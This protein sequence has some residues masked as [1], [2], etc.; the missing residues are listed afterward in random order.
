MQKVVNKCPACG[1]LRSALSAQCPE[2]GYDFHNTTCQV[3]TE[4]NN[5]LYEVSKGMMPSKKKQLEIIRSFTIPQI[6]EELLDLLI[7]I[8]PKATQKNSAVTAEWRLR[9]KE[10]IKRAKMAFAN[11]RKVLEQ[12]QQ[13]EDELTKL[14]RQFIKQW[15]QKTSTLAKAVII[16]FLVL[17]ILIL[18][19]AKDISP[20]AYAVRFTNA[21]EQGKHDKALDYLKKS[22]NMGMVI[23]EPYL[24]LVEALIQSD[25]IIEAE[26]LFQ[27]MSNYVHRG[28]N[29]D[30]LSKTYEVF[31]NYYLAKGNIAKAGTF[32][33]DSNGVVVILKS[34]IESGDT[35]A[36]TKFYN[37][38][39]NKLV[40]YDPSVRQRV[41]KCDDEVVENF[42]LENNLLR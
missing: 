41:L 39:S 40:K 27:N 19:P 23:A 16:T 1:A 36:A 42:V 31:I 22:P 10:V 11:E 33:N 29:A 20:E 14:E 7:Y 30:H 21:V 24:T 28:D 32:V 4:L 34:L 5:R 6:K 8:Q 17:I 3:I 2:C 37:R 9:Q 12:V 15:W 26:S 13:Y 18:I 38:H 35:A 25:R